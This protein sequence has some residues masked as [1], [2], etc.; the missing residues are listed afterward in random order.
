MIS[1][2]TSSDR[3]G[4]PEGYQAYYATIAK[5]FGRSHPYVSLSYS[6]FERKILIPFGI[7]VAICEEFSL[8]AMND[9]RKS[10]LLLFYNQ[11]DY[12]IARMYIWLRNPGI[13]LS[14]G[15]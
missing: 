12:N 2:G 1:L 8:L 9:G 3:V 10:H 7:D 11:Q 4:T 13:S 14:F 5:G 6:E 15:F